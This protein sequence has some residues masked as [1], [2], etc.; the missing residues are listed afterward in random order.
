VNVSALPL[1]FPW[2]STAAPGFNSTAAP[3]GAGTSNTP[4]GPALTVTGLPPT[5]NVARPDEA[6]AG[7]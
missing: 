2:P 7:R 5:R 3:D 6:F 4:D 1:A